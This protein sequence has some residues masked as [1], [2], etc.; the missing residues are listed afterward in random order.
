MSEPSSGSCTAVALAVATVFGLFT[1]MDFGILISASFSM[2]GVRRDDA[3]SKYNY[4]EMDFY[5]ARGVLP[6]VLN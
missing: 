4:Y 6:E 1:G 2:R 5:D 3:R